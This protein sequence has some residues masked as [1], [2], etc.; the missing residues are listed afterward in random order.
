MTN[1]VYNRNFVKEQSTKFKIMSATTDK[2]RGNWNMIKGQLK[3]KYAQ[4]TDNDLVYAEGQEEQLLG[5]LQQ[6]LGK[7]KQEVENM[8]DQF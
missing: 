8:I 4:L 5:R 2:I 3:E 6:K 1:Q 7:S